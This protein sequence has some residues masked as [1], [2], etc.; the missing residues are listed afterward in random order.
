VQLDPNHQS[1]DVRDERNRRAI[2]GPSGNLVWTLLQY[3]SRFGWKGLA[4][5]VLVILGLTGVQTFLSGGV[6][7]GSTDNDESARFVG[8]VLDDVQA[9]WDATIP[10]YQHTQLVLFR[11]RYPTGCGTGDAAMGPFYCPL[12]RTVYLD[13]SFFDELAQRFGAPGDFARAYVVAHEVGHHLQTLQG[14]D[15][16][17]GRGRVQGAEGGSV[18]LELQADCYA[19][20]WGSVAKQR[21]ILDPGDVE[22]GLKAAAS[23]GDDRLQRETSGVVVPDS[24][25]HGTSAQRVRWLRTGLESGS[26]RACDTFSADPL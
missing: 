16:K 17:T 2:R 24:F 7:P 21:G 15:A 8:A 12:D 23:I 22:E 1:G 4:V 10:G 9:T 14:I 25:T 5:A 26:L 19:G 18:R 6:T 11:D 3:G 20:V 13:L